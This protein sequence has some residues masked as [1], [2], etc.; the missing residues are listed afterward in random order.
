MDSQYELL[1]RNILYKS[2]KN[3]IVLDPHG[4]IH[5]YIITLTYTYTITYIIVLGNFHCIYTAIFI[6]VNVQLCVYTYVCM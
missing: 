4:Y 6:A 2:E 1:L 5:T 3:K